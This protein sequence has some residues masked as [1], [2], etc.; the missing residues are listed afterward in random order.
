MPL[1]KEQEWEHG[2]QWA[3]WKIEEDEKFFFDHLVL[4]ESESAEV[5]QL[6]G[7]R[8]LEWLA[9]RYLVHLMVSDEPDWDRIPLLKDEFGK[10]HLDDHELYVS[11][12]H[13]YDFVAVI[14][15]RMTVG[16]DIQKFVPKITALERKFMREEESVS[17]GK[18]SRLEHLHIYWG[19]KE[20][21]Y[22]CYGRRQLDFKQHILVEPFAYQES[23]KTSGTVSK[24][25]FHQTYDIFFEKSD[26]YFLVHALETD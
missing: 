10:P 3:V 6:K 19:A 22:K 11:F 4:H 16:I 17:L 2:H 23:G 13:S 14:L 26:N 9:S 12:S 18:M 15:G 24:N 7:R 8:R 21:L 25:G 20:A 5:A 1:W